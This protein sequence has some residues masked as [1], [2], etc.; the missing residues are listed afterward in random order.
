[1]TVISPAAT[2]TYDPMSPVSHP[3]EP[4]MPLATSAPLQR[5]LDQTIKDFL[6]ET[7]GAIAAPLAEGLTE[8]MYRDEEDEEEEGGTSLSFFHD[9]SSATWGRSLVEGGQFDGLINQ[10][11]Y[12]IQLQQQAASLGGNVSLM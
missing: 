9:I 11:K 3:P 12:M 8:D 5:D 1:M 7:L 10:M 2:L 4:L 6:V